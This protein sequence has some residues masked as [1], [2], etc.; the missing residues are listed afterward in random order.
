[1]QLFLVPDRLMRKVVHSENDAVHLNGVI[2]T[3]AVL[4]AVSFSPIVTLV[5]KFPHVCLLEYLFDIPCP[6]CGITSALL[7]ISKL[8]VAK[9][10][11]LHPCGILIP[12][13][14]VFHLVVRSLCLAGCLPN[15]TANALVKYSGN[16]L[17]G[18]L[19][20]FWMIRL[21]IT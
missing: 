9:S 15:L 20:C 5:A 14:L 2:S 6:G 17:V 16:G 21:L 11:S 13:V 3:L 7:A 8:E 4:F 18:A 19:F 1:M 10:I 12:L